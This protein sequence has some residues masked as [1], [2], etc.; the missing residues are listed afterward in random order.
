M[1]LE[2]ADGQMAALARRMI[3]SVEVKAEAVVK[4]E[5]AAATPT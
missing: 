5:S 3:S 1:L 4:T 2:T